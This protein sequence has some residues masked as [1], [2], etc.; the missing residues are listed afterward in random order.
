MLRSGLLRTSLIC[1]VLVAAGTGMIFAFGPNHAIL[2]THSKVVNDTNRTLTVQPCWDAACFDRR[3]L[4]PVVV[5]P[6]GTPRVAG[7]FANDVPQS[8]VVAI[9]RPGQP[10]YPPFAS[11]VIGHFPPGTKVAVLRLS[12]SQQCPKD[13]GANG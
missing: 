3:R 1:A 13:P 8:I 7:R 11:C 5:P 4:S 6:G 2:F 12:Q 9:L 10:D